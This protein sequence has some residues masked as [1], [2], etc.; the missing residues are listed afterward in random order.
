LPAFDRSDISSTAFCAWLG[1]C[2]GPCILKVVLKLKN[3]HIGKQM[4]IE[5]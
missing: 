3:C 1:P 4:L 5:V 2:E